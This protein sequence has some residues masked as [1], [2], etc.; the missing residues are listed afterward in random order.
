MLPCLQSTHSSRSTIPVNLSLNP[1]HYKTTFALACGGS[2]LFVSADKRYRTTADKEA[3]EI[4]AKRRLKSGTL[5]KL[6]YGS[7]LPAR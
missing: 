5:E 7:E 4:A 1:D 6:G 2:K 3:E